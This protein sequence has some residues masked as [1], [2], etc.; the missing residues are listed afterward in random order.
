M[1]WH[2]PVDCM[3]SVSR[4]GCRL[5]LDCTGRDNCR[6]K[7]RWTAESGS[8]GSR[9]PR[10]PDCRLQRQ[11]TPPV[12]ALQRPHAWLDLTRGAAPD[13]PISAHFVLQPR[14]TGGL[15]TA[16]RPSAL[17]RPAGGLRVQPYTRRNMP[18]QVFWAD[19]SRHRRIHNPLTRPARIETGLRSNAR[20]RHRLPRGPVCTPI[21][22]PG[23]QRHSAPSSACRENS[24]LAS[25]TDRRRGMSST[26][27]IARH[28][29]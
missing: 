25:R 2:R 24:V 29:W 22:W 19:A 6:S 23:L 11:G 12:Q 9:R 5:K 26:F 14:T 28:P 16:Q 15:R 21:R 4:T 20:S 10:A 13:R 3:H 18:V 27:G 8:G 7:T 17:D 1:D